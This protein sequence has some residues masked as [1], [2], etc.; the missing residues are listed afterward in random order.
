MFYQSLPT[1]PVRSSDYQEIVNTPWSSIA[2]V[3]SSPLV[4]NLKLPIINLPEGIGKL[5]IATNSL[6]LVPID[7]DIREMVGR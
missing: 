2:L 7:N 4:T 3:I 1:N 6:S 5:P